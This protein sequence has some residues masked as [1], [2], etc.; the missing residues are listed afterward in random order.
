MSDTALGVS[1]VT[2]PA[3]ILILSEGR[4]LLCC[5]FFDKLTDV[6]SHC[7]KLGKAAKLVKIDDKVDANW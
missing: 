1:S 3:S 5:H 2:W 4:L 6:S 7:N